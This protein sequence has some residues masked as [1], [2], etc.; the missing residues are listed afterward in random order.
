MS[1]SA[2]KIFSCSAFSKAIFAEYSALWLD[3]TMS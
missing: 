1:V 2:H 3:F